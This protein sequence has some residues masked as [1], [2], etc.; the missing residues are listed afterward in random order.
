[1]TPLL[2]RFTEA[3]EVVAARVA[4][5]DGVGSL[6]AHCRELA[7]RCRGAG[8]VAECRKSPAA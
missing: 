2:G 6:V 4:V 1:M 7:G 3:A 5:F 8:A